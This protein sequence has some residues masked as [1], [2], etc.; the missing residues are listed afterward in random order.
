MTGR[1]EASLL[2]SG[3]SIEHLD[4]KRSLFDPQ[5]SRLFDKRV[6]NLLIVRTKN[7]QSTITGCDRIQ[8]PVSEFQEV[9]INIPLPFYP[10]VGRLAV[11]SLYQANSGLARYQTFQVPF[12]PIQAGLN[13][14]PDVFMARSSL[15]K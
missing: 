1:P 6:E 7:R 13:A 12:S 5:C 4:L 11:C 3:N 2:V 14:Y 8:H 15:F 10:D 9:R